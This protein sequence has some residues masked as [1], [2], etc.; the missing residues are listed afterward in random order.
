[1]KIF[2]RR[3]AKIQ[4]GY[5]NKVRNYKLILKPQTK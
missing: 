5:N 3:F 1:M 4:E 2:Q